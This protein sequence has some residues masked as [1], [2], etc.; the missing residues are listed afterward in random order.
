VLL[1]LLC[2]TDENMCC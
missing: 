2:M 1:V